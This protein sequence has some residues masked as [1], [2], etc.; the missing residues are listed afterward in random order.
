MRTIATLQGVDI[1]EH[2]DGRVT[3]TAK[4]SIDA[5]GSNGITSGKAAYMVGNKG[6]DHLA[7]G[8]MKM[9][10]GK[11]VV[12]SSWAKDIVIMSGGQPKEF[13]GGIIASKTTY[14]YPGVP[15]D[16]PA[17]YVDSETVPYFVVP[18]VIRQKVKG[19]VLGCLVKATNTKNGKTSQGPVA[20]IGPKTKIGELSM[21]AAKELGLDPN[22]RVGG[23]SD[24]IIKYEVFPG[25][26]APG[27][28]LQP[29]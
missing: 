18:P 23:T 11:V 8:G 20:D 2:D 5:D 7:N 24:K 25:T 3:F 16:S 26:P 1:I 15:K 28:K 19:V 13:P 21:A 17:A 22:P 9:Q 14:S 6:H 29:A 12:N 10:G 4:A 27:F